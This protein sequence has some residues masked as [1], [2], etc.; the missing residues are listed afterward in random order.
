[1]MKEQLIQKRKEL[2]DRLGSITEDYKRGLSADSEERAQELE[3]R[4][5]LQE[6]ER[7]TREEIAKINEK[8]NNLE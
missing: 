1:M 3:N 2:Q 6:I 8:L 4:E 5:T 7:V